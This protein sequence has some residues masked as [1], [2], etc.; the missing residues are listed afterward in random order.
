MVLYYC[1]KDYGRGLCPNAVRDGEKMLCNKLNSECPIGAMSI[2]EA[3]EADYPYPSAF[4][5]KKVYKNYSRA[6]CDTY[7][8][9]TIVH[10]G[11]VFA[12]VRCS[13]TFLFQKSFPYEGGMLEQKRAEWKARDWCEGQLFKMGRDLISFC[14]EADLRNAE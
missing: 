8:L 13:N 1:L 6:V 14:K 5:W 3:G 10:E 12:V 2:E 4:E 7:I 11:Y 9:E